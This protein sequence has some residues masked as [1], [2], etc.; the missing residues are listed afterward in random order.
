MINESKSEK[1]KILSLPLNYIINTIILNTLINEEESCNLFLKNR[2]SIGKRSR[3]FLEENYFMFPRLF[4]GSFIQYL[5]PL[6]A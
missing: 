3:Y 2:K 5:I 4:L 1:P 6:P